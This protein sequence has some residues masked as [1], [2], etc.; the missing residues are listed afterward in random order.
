M[1]NESQLQEMTDCKRH[2]CKTLH[3]D[4][5]ENISTPSI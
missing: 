5:R 3:S 1:K 2:F 4:M